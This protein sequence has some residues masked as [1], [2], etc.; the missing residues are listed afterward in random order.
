MTSYS[1]SIFRNHA[2]SHCYVVHNA[3]YIFT[4]GKLHELP[5]SCQEE[6][7]WWYR[8]MPISSDE[9]LRLIG[10]LSSHVSYLLSED[11]T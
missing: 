5:L 1:A 7:N 8:N 6:L 4:M 11:K 3:N 10:L 2:A 9:M